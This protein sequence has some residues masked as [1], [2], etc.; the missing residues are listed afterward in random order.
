M[1]AY[2]E[3][4][5][6]R[7]WRAW[8]IAAWTA[9]AALLSLPLV[10]M[11][12][13]DDVD[14]TGL[15]FLVMGVLLFACCAA[16]HLGTRRARNFAHLAGVA[17]A[18]G[19]SFLLV[20][21]NLAV[22]IIGGEDAPANLMYFGVV[23]VAIVASLIAGS[24]PRGLARAMCAA[25]IAEALVAIAVVVMGFGDWRS[26]ALSVSFVVPWLAAAALFTYS[27]RQP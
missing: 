10:A 3:H 11:Q 13:T 2:L 12:F 19:A 5:S 23:A 21:I 14:W 7:Q 26:I 4:D 17:V 9:A 20:W 18:V 27:A 22:G 6:G 25:A 16:F 24:D 8:R 15:D 1:A